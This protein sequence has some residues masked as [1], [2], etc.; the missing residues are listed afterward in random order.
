MKRLIPLL[1]ITILCCA[2]LASSSLWRALAADCTR[3]SMGLIPLNDLGAG[4]YNGSQG[5]LY[6]GGTNTRPSAHEIAGIQQSLA[7]R[8]LDANGQPS[9]SGKYVLLSIGMS[10]T[11]QEF[12]TFKMIADAD[13]RKNPN[14][15]IVDG[16][17]GGQDANDWNNPT[18]NTWINANTRLTQAGVTAQQVQVVWLKQ[19]FAGDNLAAFPTDAA[20]LRD[21]LRGIALIAKS[22][23]PNLR[24]LYVS[25]RIYG[26]Y[27][28]PLRGKG[29]YENGF[30]VKWLVE[31]QINGDPR[32]AYTGSNPPAPWIAWGPYMWADG[33]TPRS[34]GLIWQCSDFVD[35][36]IHPSPT[37]R[38][39]VAGMLLNFFKSDSTARL[40]FLNSRRSVADF[41]GDGKSDISVFRN[42]T[43]YLNQSTAGF[44]AAQFGASTDRL[45]P[46]DYDVDGK[47]DI[48]V[49]R[50]GYWYWLQSSD[51]AFRAAQ[52]GTAGDI[53]VP[54]DFTGDGRAELAVYRAGFWYTLNLANNQFNA[55]QFG[56][57]SDKPVAGD[58]DGDGKTDYAVYRDGTWYLL[59]STQGFTA[60]QF[61]VSTDKPVVADYDGDGKTDAA[62]YRSGFWYLLRSTQGFTAFQF[63][64]ASDVP[65]P[66]DYDGDGKADAAV[67][68]DGVWH[69]LRSQQ[70][71]QSSQFG[72]AGDTPIPYVSIP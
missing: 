54:S 14:L 41:D 62:V 49:F 43:W 34:D 21:V 12:S 13:P 53:P 19:Q 68:R 71:F 66:A 35:D 30:A 16:A 47:T 26:N 58:Y 63:G 8:P 50:D 36:G 51:G 45:A 20:R 3:T 48:A 46:A 40:W 6:P 15:V 67:Y 28:G 55:V 25:S 24:V 10:N 37:A 65:A 39:K 38:Q 4:T 57:A 33:L 9:A 31:D 72:M 64:I 5:G 69:M 59:Q 7:V 32:L 56:V 44:R 23:Y 29:A 1:T 27:N 42:G 18:S 22:K 17:Q 61:G 60:F 2:L 70:G 52:F 11:T